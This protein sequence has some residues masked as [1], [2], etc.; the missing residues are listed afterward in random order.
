MQILLN[1]GT[2]S[3]IDIRYRYN[4]NIFVKKLMSIIKPAG[5][6]KKSY[7]EVSQRLNAE[8]L[9]KYAW[10]VGMIEGDGWFSIS[11]K[12]KYL[13]YEFG[14]ELAVRDVQLI[15]KIKNILGIGTVLFRNTEGRSNTV[16]LRVRNKTHLKDLI[17]PIFDKYPLISNKQYDYLRF[18]D[19]LLKGIIYSEDFNSNYIRP[20]I[21]L[22]SVESIINLNYFSAWLVGFIE[23]EGC[24]SIYK[25]ISSTSLIA[26]FEVSQ[27][28]GEILIL[29]IC[30][31]LS[32]TQ[33]VHRD[34][35]NCFRIKVSS[36]RSIEN[37]INFMQ[38]APVQLMGFKKLQY[39]LWLKELRSITRY[40]KKINIPDTY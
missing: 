11:K 13:T 6:R 23:A 4:S 32:F 35:T 26:S 12:G 3:N 1:A 30:K 33:K 24:F 18:K 2:Y 25:P 28:D 5:I 34:N 40:N 37:V 36:V 31:Y 20:T 38:K 9:N 10:L 7:F 15:Y 16:I 19:N 17:L 8:N 14:I 27:T 29:A 21:P 39:L 22:N